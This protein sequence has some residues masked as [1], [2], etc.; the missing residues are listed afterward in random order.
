[1]PYVFDLAQTGSSF[2]GDSIDVQYPGLSIEAWIK[3]SNGG[4]RAVV[5]CVSHDSRVVPELRLSGNHLCVVWSTHDDGDV[6]IKSS[7]SSQI[8]DDTWHHIAATLNYDA[9]KVTASFYKD[10]TYTDT[11]I[12]TLK[13]R[14]E[15]ASATVEIGKSP[16][17]TASSFKGLIADV[18]IWSIARTAAEIGNC[19]AGSI[20]ARDGTLPDQVRGWWPL[21]D[22]FPTNQATNVTLTGSGEAVV[23]WIEATR[24]G[25]FVWSPMQEAVH[26]H[27]SVPFPDWSDDQGKLDAYNYIGQTLYSLGGADFRQAKYQDW[28]FVNATE[29]AQEKI[30]GVDKSAYE[31][32]GISKGHWEAVTSQLFAEFDCI[33]N[34]IPHFNNLI[35]YHNALSTR[36]TDDSGA[37][38]HTSIL[39]KV[40]D[41]VDT[42][43]SDSVTSGSTMAVTS[44]ILSVVGVVPIPGL[45]VATTVVGAGLS[46]VSAIAAA[47]QQSA[48]A[49]FD[50]EVSDV[51]DQIGK[52]FTD[53]AENIENT[54]FTYITS[55][56]GRL[57]Y[58]S[59]LIDNN[60]LSWP[61]KTAD[62]LAN[63][64][65]DTGFVEC[66]KILM[67]VRFDIFSFYQGNSVGE[68]PV[69]DPR[70]EPEGYYSRGCG[71]YSLAPSHAVFKDVNGGVTISNDDADFPSSDLMDEMWKDKYGITQDEF[72]N[73]Y[74]GWSL[75]A[76][77]YQC[78]YS[79]GN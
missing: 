46:A 10:G 2:K 19:R 32:A 30:N 66:L 51:R 29:H 9:S 6:V 56:W 13:G 48:E 64:V 21:W 63:E 26:M 8:T 27:P 49:L 35:D 40:A 28:D 72:F 5:S 44:S 47:E 42:S 65:Y 24:P 17:G 69:S 58:F 55:D 73:G 75:E 1:M 62:E 4:E 18:R 25:D 78:Q 74:N 41:F 77:S 45:S 23:A 16:T 71:D 14:H 15:S 61:N 11:Q 67:P 59:G 70:T 36:F 12:V 7:D 76:K 33:S 31:K 57:Q 54:Y 52:Y 37:N 39:T 43:D 79:T 3:T 38:G 60:T 50:T 22:S 68:D 34:V 20:A 53:L